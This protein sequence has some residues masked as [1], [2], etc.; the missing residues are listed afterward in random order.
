MNAYEV[1]NVA[2]NYKCL[3]VAESFGK[4]EENY[5]YVYNTA[6]IKEIKLIYENVILGEKSEVV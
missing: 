3:V 4:A 2:N 1:T 6:T 5:L